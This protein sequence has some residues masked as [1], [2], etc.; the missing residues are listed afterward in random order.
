MSRMINPAMM[1]VS[2]MTLRIGKCILHLKNRLRVF[3][4]GIQGAVITSNPG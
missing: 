2:T 4:L 1:G 3:K